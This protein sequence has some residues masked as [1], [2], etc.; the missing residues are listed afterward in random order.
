MQQG[1]LDDEDA[2]LQQALLESAREAEAAA[3]AAPPTPVGRLTQ[4]VEILGAFGAK[5]R[6]YAAAAVGRGDLDATGKVLLPK[7]A[8]LEITAF[9]AGELP[10]T[11]LLQLSAGSESAANCVKKSSRL[12]LRKRVDW[13]GGEGVR[14][15]VSWSCES[16][17]RTS[18]ARNSPR[19]GA[20]SGVWRRCVTSRTRS[21][22]RARRAEGARTSP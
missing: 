3:A 1:D 12:T 7:S 15:G 2:L 5:F 18:V 17:M 10:P 19:A 4:G 21:S 8:L 6:C 22:R 13:R 20:E 9:C 16:S 11:L 14:S